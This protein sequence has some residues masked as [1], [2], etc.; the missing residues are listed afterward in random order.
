MGT[1]HED[2]HAFLRAEI[3]NNEWDPGNMVLTWLGLLWLPWKN[4]KC[5]IL[6]NAPL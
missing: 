2:L 1:L 3:T 5:E 4:I 6:V